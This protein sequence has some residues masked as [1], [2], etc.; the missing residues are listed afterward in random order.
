MPPDGSCLFHSL[1]Y[2]LGL[3][4][5]PSLRKEIANFIAKNPDLE[6]AGDPLKDWIAWDGGGTVSSY[7]RKMANPHGPWGGGIEMAACSR[8]VPMLPG[9]LPVRRGQVAESLLFSHGSSL[10]LCGRLHRCNVH[11][12]EKQRLRSGFKWI[13]CFDN[14]GATKTVHVLYCGGVH[15]NALSPAK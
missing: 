6:I 9:C 15:Y 12:Y 4:S 1:C 7:T 8:C 13:S 10:Q 2:G 11:V 3:S 14:R 5:A